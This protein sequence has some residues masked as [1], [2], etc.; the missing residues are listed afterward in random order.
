MVADLLEQGRVVF[1]SKWID[2]PTRVKIEEACVRLGTEQLRPTKNA[3]PQEITYGQIRLVAV[4][5]R[6]KT[7]KNAAIA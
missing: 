2:E 6:L 1:D 3:L 5:M 4:Q 7:T